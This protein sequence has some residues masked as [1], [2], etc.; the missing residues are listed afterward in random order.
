M[1]ITLV[2]DEEEKQL[3]QLASRVLEFWCD[4]KDFERCLEEVAA[5][6]RSNEEASAAIEMLHRL[7][8]KAMEPYALP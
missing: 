3:G 8:C 1:Q 2:F 4:M 7:W 5:D 6:N